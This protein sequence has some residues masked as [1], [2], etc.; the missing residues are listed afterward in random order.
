MARSKA[1]A[2]LTSKQETFAVAY[3]ISGRATDAYREAYDVDQKATD[4]WIHVEACQLL[5][6]PKIAPRIKEL[7]DAAKR[8]SE[9]TVFKALDELEEA[10]KLAKR[11]DNPSAMVSAT[12]S[13]VKVL[14]MDRPARI[15]H[16]SSDGSM[17]PPSMSDAAIAKLTKKLTD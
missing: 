6:H 13:K 7:Q 12:N 14:G 9:F 16:T 1:T 11:T 17:T 10:R 8:R 15:D 2:G 4:S 3:S 5:D